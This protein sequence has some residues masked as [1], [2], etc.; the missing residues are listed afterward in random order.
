MDISE[1]LIVFNMVLLFTC[2]S[3]MEFL[4]GIFCLVLFLLL[5]EVIYL[6]KNTQALAFQIFKKVGFQLDFHLFY[7][8]CRLLNHFY[9]FVLLHTP[10]K[11]KYRNLRLFQ[12]LKKLL[13]MP[14]KYLNQS[15]L[16]Y[17]PSKHASLQ[18]LA[19]R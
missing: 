16:L 15:V 17:T 4:F 8:F 11:Q 12:S 19:H 2:S 6:G 14:E 13:Q 5:G 9:Y 1:A 18:H 10:F 3:I 7:K